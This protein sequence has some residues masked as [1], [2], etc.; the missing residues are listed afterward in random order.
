[1][2]CLQTFEREN[3]NILKD[4]ESA[5][6]HWMEIIVHSQF[7][8]EQKCFLWQNTLAHMAGYHQ[9]CIHAPMIGPGWNL[10]RNMVAMQALKG[11]LDAT[12]FVIE[13]C[14]G[15]YS[16]QSNESL[17]RRKLKFATKDVK[18]GFTWHARAMVP[19]FHGI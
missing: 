12:Q 18:W 17:H 16:T 9:N 19:F 11:F 15:I 10:A 1:M 13:K 4:I 7:T 8:V 6:T 5:L 3:A 14:C 2:R